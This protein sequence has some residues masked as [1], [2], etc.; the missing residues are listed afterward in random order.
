LYQANRKE[1]EVLFANREK[2]WALNASKYGITEKIGDIF[3]GLGRDEND[4]KILG[5]DTSSKTFPLFVERM[6]D[7]RKTYTHRLTL[8][9]SQKVKSATAGK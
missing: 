3:P 6:I 1:R 4:Y 8:L 5:W 9:P 7:G 2:E